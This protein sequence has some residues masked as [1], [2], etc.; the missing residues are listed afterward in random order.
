MAEPAVDSDMAVP[1]AEKY[2]RDRSPDREDLREDVKR[3]LLTG[4]AI[5]VPLIITLLVLSIVLNFITGLMAPFV[6]LAQQ[7]GL[8]AGTDDV[9][10]HVLAF[11]MLGGLVFA[12][13]A[14]AERRPDDGE[15]TQSFHDAME[16]IPGVGSIYTSVNLMSEVMLNSDTESFRD[17]KLVE[18]P[19][20]ETYAIAFLTANAPESV[21]VSVAHE[22]MKTLFVP[23]AP[24]PFMGGQLV[25]VPD[26]RVHDVDMSVEQGV[27]AI[28]TSGVAIDETAGGTA[29]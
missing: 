11:V 18:F 3:T 7:T 10:V 17:V 12:V 28:V 22:E 13:G 6:N 23:F 14:V 1:D 5:L 24:N 27:Q 25:V 4:T 15:I 2:L 8:T 19:H 9:L 21:E 29:R 20:S 26:H 16:R